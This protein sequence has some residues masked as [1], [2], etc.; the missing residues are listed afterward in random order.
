MSDVLRAAGSSTADCPVPEPIAT[1]A[2]E[3]ALSARFTPASPGREHR[4]C[5]RGIGVEQL[6]TRPVSLDA[7]EHAL[8]S[9]FRSG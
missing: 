9:N 7:L 4:Q 3:R 5:F 8:R 6:L 2:V 1:A